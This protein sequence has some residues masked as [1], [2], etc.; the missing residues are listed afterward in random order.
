MQNSGEIIADMLEDHLKER[1]INNDLTK[2]C[3][4]WEG[5]N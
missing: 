5:K 2:F 1:K 4:L 3:C